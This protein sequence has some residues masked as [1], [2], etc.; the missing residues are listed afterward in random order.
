MIRRPKTKTLIMHSKKEEIKVHNYQELRQP[1]TIG[2]Y[3]PSW[4]YTKFTCDGTKSLCCNVDENEEKDA[5]L[6]CPSPKDASKSSPEVE[7]VCMAKITF[8]DDDLLLGKFVASKSLQN[9]ALPTRR[10]DEGFY[11]NAYR[12]L[13]KAGYNPTEPSKIGKA[14]I[15]TYCKA[16][17]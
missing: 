7:D 4:F 10:T 2:E 3:F 12:L 17:T 5:T 13:E 11:P 14:S 9:E 6:S 16:T 15:R 1:I 8:S